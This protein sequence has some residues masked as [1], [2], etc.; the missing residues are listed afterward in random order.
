LIL[1]RDAALP[2]PDPATDSP[3]GALVND[4]APYMVSTYA[5]PSPVFV[6][7][8]GSYL[9]DVENRK[10]LDFTAGIAVNALGHC[11]PEF[12]RIVADQVCPNPLPD[13]TDL[14]DALLTRHPVSSRKL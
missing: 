9:Y 3:S 10:Y 2:N 7:G 14:L 11:D 5:R 13:S 12:A 4:W 8:E 6:Q 1:Q